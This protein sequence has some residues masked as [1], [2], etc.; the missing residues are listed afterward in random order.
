MPR[1]GGGKA[2]SSSQPQA[3]S[4]AQPPALWGHHQTPPHE[5]LG[6]EGLSAGDAEQP[7]GHQLVALHIHQVEVE[8]S[9]AS[10]A[11][12]HTHKQ[13]Q[14]PIGGQGEH[15][16]WVHLQTHRRGRST[17]PIRTSSLSS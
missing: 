2:V 17:G 13:I 15:T 7:G 8:E 14:D 16:C 12:P 10:P 4:T 5:Y 3:V 9:A 1:A 6:N 11:W